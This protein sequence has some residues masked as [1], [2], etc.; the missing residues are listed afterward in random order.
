MIVLV[1][2]LILHEV[3]HAAG[4]CSSAEA[5]ADALFGIDHH[6][7]VAVA[8]VLPGDGRIGADR[9]AYAA[10]PAGAAGRAMGSARMD[11]L[12]AQ[13]ARIEIFELYARVGYFF[14]PGWAL[15][16]S[17]GE[18]IADFSGG[19]FARLRLLRLADQ[20]LQR[21]RPRKS[22]DRWSGN[23]RLPL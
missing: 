17:S 12:E 7:E 2:R 13:K 8:F 14:P 21:R 16:I 1:E 18:K 5:A 3:P 11:S 19:L 15:K 23:V 22:S 9:G 4:A 20:A 10:V 6:F